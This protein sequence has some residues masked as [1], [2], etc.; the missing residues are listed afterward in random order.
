[1]KVISYDELRLDLRRWLDS[2]DDDVE[3]VVIRRE[4]RKDLVVIPL[5]AYTAL[6]ETDYLLSGKNREVL[7]RSIEESRSGK[8]VYRDLR[9]P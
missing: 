5:E 9:E 3:E 1:M 4:D 2:V 8:K 7:L 6:T